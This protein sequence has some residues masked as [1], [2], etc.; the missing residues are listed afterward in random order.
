MTTTISA[1]DGE[2]KGERSSVN[3]R[4][5]FNTGLHSRGIFQ[6]KTHALAAL[7]SVM[8]TCTHKHLLT[9][10]LSKEKHVL[11]TYNRRALTVRRL[12]R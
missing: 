12:Y 4:C 3:A 11:Y 2:E 1:H 10:A 5:V 8:L 9:G 6:Y 7:L